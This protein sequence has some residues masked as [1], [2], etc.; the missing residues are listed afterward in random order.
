MSSGEPDAGRRKEVGGFGPK[1]FSPA[2]PPSG[3][4]AGR[5]G[6][7]TRTYTQSGVDRSSVAR[8]LAAMLAEIRPSA[9]PSHGRPVSLPGH[10]AGL[11]RLGR[12]TVAVTTDTVGTKVILARQMGRW[13]E[14]G[15][16]LVA[17]NVNDLAAVGARPS[18]LVDTIVCARPDAVRFRK[19][20]RGIHRG[21]VAARCSLLGGETAVV[22]DLVSDIDL[23]GTAVGFFPS[24]R[25]PVTGRAIRPGDRILG[26]PSSG[27]HANGF[28][29]LRRV[30]TEAGFD[31][32]RPR[33]GGRRAV[34]TELLRPTRIYSEVIDAI[35]DRPGVH[36][37]AH[38]SGGGVRNLVRLRP[39][40]RF[41]LEEWPAVPPLFGWIARTGHLSVREMFQTFNMGIGFAVVAAA[42]SVDDLLD[43]LHRL[44]APDALEIGRVGPG[45]GVAVPEWGLDYTGYA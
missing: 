45:R 30:L 23:G 31:P 20:G 34:G 10:F 28:T 24:G 41:S 40:V 2:V 13:E 44:G 16:D 33:P 22:P 12:E 25:T 36:G 14:V 37:L 35:A 27:V 3:V 29:L 26:I 15:E 6:T 17:I 39:S 5:R 38:I 11:V 18:G 4:V 8:S 19:I 1:V 42:R 32:R 43:R 7:R 9:P 21:L